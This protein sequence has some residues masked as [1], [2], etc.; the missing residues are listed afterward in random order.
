MSAPQSVVALL[1]SH[2]G[3]RW[4]PAVLQGLAAQTHPVDH[5]LA[6][7]TGSK[8]SSVALLE[9]APGVAQVL[10]APGTTSFPAAVRLGLDAVAEAGLDPEWVWLLHDDANPDP[11]C[12]AA[13]LA[14][15][16]ADPG[17]DL[18][19]PK[20]REWPSLRRLLEL[21]VTISAT[22]RRET[23]LERGEYDQGQHDRVRTVLAVNT[24]GMLVRRRVLESLGGL[25]EA[26]PLF[27]NDIDLG[28]RAAEAGHRTI[29]VPQAVV[30][31]A[32]AAHRGLRRTPLT[33]RHTHYQ[34]RRAALFTLLANAP[35]R[36]LPFRTVRLALGTLLR[37]L[38][39]LLVRAVGESLDEL[40][41]LISV[42]THPGEVRA[43]RRRRREQ[44]DGPPVD[45]RELL[46]P[47]W[48][49]YRHGLDFLGDLVSALSL[50]ASDVAERRRLAA[51]E[52]DPSSFAARRPT[53]S[54]SYD[55]DTL[56]A[57]SGIVARFV[58]NPVALLLSAFVLLALVGARAA[59]GTLVGGGL[60]P[61]PS[62]AGE[63]WRLYLSSWHEIG[64]GTAV[65]TP[66]YVVALA[67]LATL[68]L[69]SAKA[70]VT[71]VMVLA[72]PVAL[73]GAW[74]FLRVV[75]RLISPAGASRWLVLLGATTYALVPVTSGAW[76]DGRLGVVVS[77]ATLPWLAHAA[78]GFA[79]PAPQRRWRAAWRTGV[80]LALISAF[81][82]VAWLVTVAVGLV[83]L[84]AAA[85]V[86]RS[87]V[88]ERSVWGPPATAVA[89]VPLLLAP[90][91]IPAVL[92]SAA[93][94]LLLDV[95]RLP[96]ATVEGIG[97]LAGRFAD[98]GAPLALGL[99]PAVLAVLALVPR[100][101]RVPVLVCWLVAVVTAAV[102]AALG[103]VSLD[104]AAVT[105]SPGTGFLLVL[106]QGSFVVAAVIGAQGF[107]ARV[108]GPQGAAPVARG[109]IAVLAAVAAVVPAAGLAWFVAGGDAHLDEDPAGG[110]PA[111]MLQSAET[112]PEH[113]ILVVRGTV[114]DG[115]TYEVRRGDGVTLG[116]DEILDLSPE[117]AGL[118]DAVRELAS[119]PTPE[120]VTDL[121]DRG[122][123]YVVLPAPADGDV[124][125]SLDATGGL[126]AASAEDRTTRA[127][128]V[129]RPL[130]AD[131]VAGPTSWLRVALLVVQGVAL[132]WVL[133]LCAPTTNRRRS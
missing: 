36:S 85:L 6:V 79:D 103:A 133:V 120:L 34:E 122:I 22:G 81:T 25:D 65:P 64:S 19:G 131:A 40:A 83:V 9:D 124:A 107:L 28:W 13:L 77:A 14:A 8:D 38:G 90:W 12:L 84:G 109:A 71:V 60:S 39:F 11:G 51:A 108:A 105:V 4:L 57:D 89:L 18:L 97:L 101:T 50:Q 48:L 75:G 26:L 118:T 67:L 55:E 111:Y 102:A 80:L 74:R 24:A 129:D 41:A 47:R 91:W 33:G 56:E 63:W 92:E 82:P 23:G 121:A 29:V 95:G 130:R 72:V 44:R 76:G 37:V 42:Y 123:E 27:G 31:H 10:R 94:G 35:A 78:L 68:L 15:A 119:S 99:V 100:A 62:G 61:V 110:I 7:D 66:A 104:L 93:E 73:W 69:G 2:D 53:P 86:V 52:A 113:G 16:E 96:G 70:A 45:V 117:D 46:A 87:A 32:E 125:A 132:L 128:Q 30:F 17:A 112:G 115:L 106:L 98:L 116:E 43:A 5:A 59:F 58:T 1:V 88:R 114:E 126:L 21:G 3:E 127:W 54:D 49:P 20:L